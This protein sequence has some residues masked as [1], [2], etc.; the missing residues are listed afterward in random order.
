MSE[1]LHWCHCRLCGHGYYW[2]PIFAGILGPCTRPNP[3]M[4][5]DCVHMQSDDGEV[6]HDHAL[7][8]PKCGKVWAPDFEDPVWKEDDENDVT[9]GECGH[10]FTIRTMITYTFTSPARIVEEESP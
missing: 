9:C 3:G 2:P 1:P 10:D 6:S 7:R 5:A 4:C 8:C